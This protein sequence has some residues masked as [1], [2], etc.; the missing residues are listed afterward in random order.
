MIDDYLYKNI[1]GSYD[2]IK[3]ISIHCQMARYWLHHR[4]L[5]HINYENC[6]GGMTFYM[7]VRNI[8]MN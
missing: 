4:I 8:M 2:I 6:V 5:M 7:L 3:S 1:I